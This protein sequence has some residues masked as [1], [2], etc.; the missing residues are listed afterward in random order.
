MAAN[1]VIKRNDAGKTFVRI[2]KKTGRGHYTISPKSS[3]HKYCEKVALEGFDRLPSGFYKNDGYCLSGAGT[4]LFEEIADKYGKE[5]SLTVTANGA[6]HIDGRG[7]K[8]RLTI[9]HRLLAEI[10]SEKRSIRSQ[11]ASE[12]RAAVQS[13]LAGNAPRQ[14]G[15]F[16]DAKPAYAPGTLANILARDRITARMNPEDEKALQEFIPQYLS[17]ISGTLRSNKKM[18]IIFDSLDAGRKIYLDKV[19]HE[20]KKKLTNKVQNEAAWQDFLKQHILLFRHTYGEVLDRSSI[21]I[22]EGKYPDFML[23]DPYSYC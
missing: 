23:I 7:R 6:F 1:Q 10:N 17:E 15:K 21:T 8:V 16:H 18:Q 3:Q 22:I 13:F 5:I 9:P 19:L 11:R 4:E 2:N 20:F 12:V 14:F